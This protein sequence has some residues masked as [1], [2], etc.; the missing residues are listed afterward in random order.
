MSASYNRFSFLILPFPHAPRLR[1]SGAPLHGGGVTGGGGGGAVRVQRDGATGVHVLG[2][3]GRRQRGRSKAVRVE[4][5]DGVGEVGA[6]A[7]RWRQWTAQSLYPRR[8]S[9]FLSRTEI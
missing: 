3:G 7:R 2:A 1:A 4:A 8:H 5:V 6:E 9:S